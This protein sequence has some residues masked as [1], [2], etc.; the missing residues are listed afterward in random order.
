[1]APDIK[2]SNIR[3][4]GGSQTDGF[5]EFAAQLFRRL[6]GVP[7]NSSFERYRGAG[8]D[9]GAE[10]VWRVA[11]AVWAMQSKF[12]PAVRQG[13]H[14]KYLDSFTRALTNFEGLS[15]Y[16]ICVPFD[17]APTVKAKIGSVGAADRVKAW[18]DEFEQLALTTLGRPVEVAWWF[19]SELK[20]RLLNMPNA[21]GRIRYWFDSAVLDVATFDGQIRSAEQLAGK[22]YT[23]KLSV[24]TDA[25]LFLGAF[26]QS[27][28]WLA[29]TQQLARNLARKIRRWRELKHKPVQRGI[30]AITDQL[31]EIR[32]NFALA[33]GDRFDAAA[34]AR[35]H[36][37]CISTRAVTIEVENYLK[38][39]FD[40][41]HGADKDT[42]G[43]RQY[44]AEYMVT[45][46][47]GDLDCAR[48][49]RS[50]LD[51]CVVY[52]DGW[53]GRASTATA[54]VMRGPAG[55]GKTHAVVDNAKDRLR[56][57]SLSVVLFGEE[58]GVGQ[59]PWTVL[60]VKLG[61]SA[62]GPRPE[63]VGA[64]EAAA[65]ASGQPLVIF[66]DALNE[67][68]ERTRWQAWLPD[69][70]G[71]LARPA[72]K[73]CLTC[74][75]IYLDETLGGLR[76]NLL[77]YPHNGFAGR[78]HDAAT[79]FAAFYDLTLPANVVAQPE[80]ASP[81][82][83][84]LVCRAVKARGETAIP[85]GSI[86]LGRL[87]DVILDATN[88]RTAKSLGYD[89]RDQNPVRQGIRSLAQQMALEGR[90]SI[91][92]GTA[93][94]LLN[95]VLPSVNHERS[96][97]RALETEDLIAV[98]D[99]SSGWSVRFAFDRLGDLLVARGL[100]DGLDENA[101]RMAFETGRLAKL[102][103]S[104]SAVSE[105]AGLL[106][107]LSIVLPEAYGV[108]LID[109]VVNKQVRSS[110]AKL[111]LDALPWR[112]A[113]SVRD[114]K[115]IW[116][117]LETVSDFAQGIEKLF[118]VAT[119]PG[120]RLNANFLHS[121]LSPWVMVDRDPLLGIAVTQSWNERGHSRRLVDLAREQDL[122]ALSPEAAVL[123]G[124]ALAWLCSVSDRRIR[125]HSTKALSRLLATHSDVAD[126]LFERF[127]RCD[128]DYIL[129]RLLCAAY[130][131]SLR[132]PQPEFIKKLA[133]LTYRMVFAHAPTP[134]NVL[135]RDT[136]RLIIEYA[137]ERG[138]DLSDIDLSS[139]RP[140]FKSRWPLSAEPSDWRA[141]HERYP[142]FPLGM[143][144]GD[145]IGTDF[146]RYVVEPRV[147]NK[148]ELDGSGFS[149]DAALRWI[150]DEVIGF[151]YPGRNDLALA[152]DRELIWRHGGGRSHPRYAERLGKKYA[153]IAVARLAGI[154]ADN[155]KA[156]SD[157]W[158]APIL[159]GGLQGLDLR[160][161]DP[162]DFNKDDDASDDGM[163]RAGHSWLTPNNRPAADR[164]WVAAKRFP[165]FE[166]SMGDWV[167]LSSSVESRVPAQDEGDD[168]DDPDYRRETHYAQMHFVAKSHQ[169]QIAR[170]I[171]HHQPRLEAPRLSDIYLGE[172][173]NHMPFR[174]LHGNA[175]MQ[176]PIGAIM[177]RFAFLEINRNRHYDCSVDD[178][179]PLLAPSP[180]LVQ[181]GDL[182]W[183][184]E[185]GWRD[186][187]NELKVQH[188]SREGE[189]TLM[190]ARDLFHRYLDAS[191]L[192]AFWVVA[193][194]KMVVRGF[195]G[196]GGVH[197]QIVVHFGHGNKPKIVQ[198][199]GRF[200]ESEEK[201]DL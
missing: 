11:G 71:T 73:L 98:T 88:G 70:L 93:R 97:L 188:V 159:P 91:P 142:K 137:V 104:D 177:T 198:C 61:M 47:A 39:E 134:E 15:H 200:I 185:R 169:E 124:V 31:A 178:P 32:E 92:L 111:M 161:I 41:T 182:H 81:L 151:G 4:E 9:G 69:M 109:V 14:R 82:F 66:I 190:M 189:Q 152:Y 168:R 101:L 52:V 17:P 84:H 96:L 140:P 199:I 150:F 34:R 193:Q 121:V 175:L 38:A 28:S 36:D 8:G 139:T 3:P 53:D 106:Q 48:E 147:L 128:D 105:N 27:S 74:R 174:Q 194:S 158:S 43:F 103:A 201:D 2:F 131:A 89:R 157:R 181:F 100:I 63:L 164:E 107:A 180:E 77:S 197:D 85:A 173:P 144:L 23:P 110:I 125:D 192:A 162:T 55:I 87:I 26:G 42:P 130:G 118:A 171:K 127:K 153:W 113:K 12:F 170:L 135:I 126:E 123:L 141:L 79:S 16:F 148:Y 20:D 143:F 154:L 22:R 50:I 1:M 6:E 195:S 117:S 54:M 21:A 184:G 156:T 46:P 44:M 68:P 167:I 30:D 13:D 166:S 145:N 58:I 49:L 7:P 116:R 76:E 24:G 176:E 33:G 112:S 83:L 59:D 51:A 102:V 5:E 37:V 129:E 132:R 191:D 183:D 18:T 78:E 119:T 120:M 136:A 19:A 196:R 25:E 45:F 94:E 90:R 133:R 99:L 108:E 149:R 86:D 95:A 146:A 64:L 40:A 122:S 57:G 67:T 72:V 179:K 62:N 163:L 35:L 114:K 10:A 65:E 56:S 187:D 75:D 160:E 29:R 60:Q 115:W 186:N 138:C 80:F 172:Y 155:V 165:R